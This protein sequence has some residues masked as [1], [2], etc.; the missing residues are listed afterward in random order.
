[1]RNFA[2]LIWCASEFRVPSGY[3]DDAEY[4]QGRQ[5]ILVAHPLVAPSVAVGSAV[6]SAPQQLA[7]Q[8]APERALGDRSQGSLGTAGAAG[9]KP[10]AS[11]RKKP[12]IH[13][14]AAS[15]NQRG[16]GEFSFTATVRH[17]GEWLPAPQE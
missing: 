15:A 4:A 3:I 11:A 1:V 10:A 9:S 8:A 17:R 2:P 7:T 14:V 13:A 6:G 5:E 16:L 12:K